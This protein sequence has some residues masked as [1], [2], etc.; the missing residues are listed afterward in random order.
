MVNMANLM[1]EVFYHNLTLLKSKF[2]E[3]NS[4]HKPLR[5][6]LAAICLKEKLLKIPKAN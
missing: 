1:L 3:E 6:N 2:Y 4:S 5:N